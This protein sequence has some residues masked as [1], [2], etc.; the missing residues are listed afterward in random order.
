M[1]EV[2]K[3]IDSSTGNDADD[4]ST[5]AL[6]KA[7]VVNAASSDAA[8]D[9]LW[10][11]AAH[12][13]L[14][15][16]AMVLSFAG[17]TISP[18][19]LVCYSG[20]DEPP[21]TAAQLASNADIGSY[22]NALTVSGSLYAYGIRFASDTALVLSG[23]SSSQAQRFENC[24]FSCAGG[25]SAGS[26]QLASN[27]NATYASVFK[28][29]TWKFGHVNN[30]PITIL[31]NHRIEGGTFYSGSSTPV[32]GVFQLATDR[33][34]GSLIV[35]GLDFSN[36]ASTVN[37]FRGGA[38][39]L[40]SGVCILRNCKL[41]ASWTGSLVTA[42]ISNPGQRYEMYNCDSGATNYRMQIQDYA[43][44]IVTNASIY[45]DAFSGGTKHSWAMS[46]S[47]IKCNYPLTGLFS[48]ELA[49]SNTTVGTPVTASV[50]VVTDGLTL[51]DRTCVLELMYPGSTGSLGTWA[52]SKVATI[53]TSS[54]NLSSSSESWTTTGLSSPT[55]QIVSV[56]FTPEAAGYILGRIVLYD[57]GT[58]V[59]VDPEIVLS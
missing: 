6:A 57:T 12:E 41:P 39:P 51:S 7:S 40:A 49:V 5:W 20:T 42:E 21:S 38:T 48:P 59:Y 3:Y 29:C 15:S 55:K 16:G 46:A 28:D 22:N 4:G 54:T 32:N 8:G 1:A 52:S 45:R 50:Y 2:H 24:Q 47:T 36:L 17:T 30:T 31:G 18:T 44:S 19:K 35:D 11:A 26:I 14:I 58:T 37:I 33:T 9:Y 25:G 23:S 13:E 56:T 43:G 34:A 10:V 27:S 53:L